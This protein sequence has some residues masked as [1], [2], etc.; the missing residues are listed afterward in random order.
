MPTG[1]P[2]RTTYKLVIL[3]DC[4][5]P[6]ALAA[7]QCS[8]TVIGFR[9]MTRF[10]GQPNRPPSICRLRSPSGK[11][12]TMDAFLHNADTA[13]PLPVMIQRISVIG[14]SG[15]AKGRASPTCHD[16]AYGHELP[17]KPS[18]RMEPMEILRAEAPCLE[19]GKGD[20][21][22]ERHLERRRRSGSASDRARFRLI[23]KQQ[24]IIGVAGQKTIAPLRHTRNRVPCREA[25][26]MISFSSAVSPELEKR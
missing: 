16:L 1:S 10:G 6:S 13:N 19:Q 24:D 2:L 26:R 12:P 11:M 8:S 25:N 17:A 21:I 15:D 4:M 18:P 7:R 9:L 14:L 22:S 5:I 3:L 23:G 20:S